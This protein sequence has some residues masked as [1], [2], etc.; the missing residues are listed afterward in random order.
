MDCHW[1]NASGVKENRSFRTTATVPHCSQQGL[2]PMLPQ[3]L[4]TAG[5]TIL[6]P[7][8]GVSLKP[9]C[10]HTA[11][12]AHRERNTCIPGQI[13]LCPQQRG[14]T[15]KAGQTR[16]THS[17]PPG[18]PSRN[19]NQILS[20]NKSWTSIL[21]GKCR[22]RPARVPLQD[23]PGRYPELQILLRRWLKWKQR[24]RHT[25]PRKVRSI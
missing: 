5:L 17:L 7:N 8:R 3:V 14:I 25:I 19:R 16:T 22:R 9:F 2:Y 11:I 15:A 4:R 1:Q 10:D 6:A 21:A 12:S 24:Q 18:S 23:T 13:F 20:G